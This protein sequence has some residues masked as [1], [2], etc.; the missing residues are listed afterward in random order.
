MLNAVFLLLLLLFC[1]YWVVHQ[2]DP[3]SPPRW[4]SIVMRV[5]VGLFV[6]VL[7]LLFWLY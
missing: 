5:L 2:L 1:G 3:V 6:G 7:G 4:V